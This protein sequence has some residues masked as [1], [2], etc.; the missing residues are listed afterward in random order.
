MGELAL[1]AET[2]AHDLN[3]I[4]RWKLGGKTACRV[5]FG[6]NKIRFN[7]RK[8]KSTYEWIKNLA[9][10]ISAKASHDHITNL[11]WRVAAKTWLEKNDLI[12]IIKSEKVLPHFSLNLCH[13]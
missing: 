7:K 2:A 9:V 11:A 6:K 3:H 5:Y 10:D 12:K 13:N 1:L 8:R 4:P